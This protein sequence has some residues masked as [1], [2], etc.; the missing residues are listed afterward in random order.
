M[1]EALDVWRRRG[2]P[3]NVPSYLKL[4]RVRAEYRLQIGIRIPRPVTFLMKLVGLSPGTLRLFHDGDFG[5]LVELRD[6]EG[7][8]PRYRHISDDLS[9]TIVK[10]ELTHEMFKQLLTPDDYIEE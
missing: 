10:G 7:A 5:F 6:Y 9:A 2:V 4:D 8:P 1:D 3:T